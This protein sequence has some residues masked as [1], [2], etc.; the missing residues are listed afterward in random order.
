[1]VARRWWLAGIMAAGMAGSVRTPA[2]A[3]P[4]SSRDEVHIGF[5]VDFLWGG[6][7][8]HLGFERHFGSGYI[9][10][11]AGLENGVLV[12]GSNVLGPCPCESKELDAVSIAPIVG[13]RLGHAIGYRIGAGPQLSYLDW[14]RADASTGA[15][16]VMRGWE[17]GGHILFGLDYRFA[18]AYTARWD[19]DYIF[20]SGSDGRD[21]SFMPWTVGLGWHF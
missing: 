20:F 17:G 11:F 3:D 7:S 10:W 16:D 13:A 9:S 12:N 4:S 8:S 21:R 19:M 1:M 5:G 14:K 18:G 6:F 15:N 2:A